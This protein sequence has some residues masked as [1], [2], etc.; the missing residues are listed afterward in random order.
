MKVTATPDG[1][2][3]F[4]LD[5]SEDLELENLKALLE[6]ESGVQ[7]SQIVIFHNG[8]P[9]SD[10]KKTLKDYGIK[11]G[12]VLLLQRALRSTQPP[13]PAQLRGKFYPKS[14]IGKLT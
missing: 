9:L 13:A 7:S 10:D 2:Q 12:D 1:D 11:D 5:V 4:S 8:V 3:I 14:L 6:F